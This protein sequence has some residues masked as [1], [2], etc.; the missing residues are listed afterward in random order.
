MPFEDRYLNALN[1]TNLLDD[2]KHHQ[3]E[4]LG[5]AALADL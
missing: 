3:T 2:D 4:A 1:S 5:A